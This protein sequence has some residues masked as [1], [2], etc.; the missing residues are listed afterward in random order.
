M[1]KTILLE[2]IKEL[3]NEI[4]FNYWKYYNNFILED[5]YN[6]DIYNSVIDFYWNS[7]KNLKQLKKYYIKNKL[8]LIDWIKNNNNIIDFS[9]SFW[10]YINK[11]L[12]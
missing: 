6:K 7:Y 11:N 12:F 4:A 10:N 3:S 5:L 8:E 2:K 9:K 1:N